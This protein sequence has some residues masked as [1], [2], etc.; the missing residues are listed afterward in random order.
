MYNIKSFRDFI[1]LALTVERKFAWERL[2]VWKTSKKFSN[3]AGS[4]YNFYVKGIACRKD[5]IVL[6]DLLLLNLVQLNR[7]YKCRNNICILYFQEKTL[8][9]LKDSVYLRIMN[10]YFWP[11]L[12]FLAYA[13]SARGILYTFDSET[14]LH[15]YFTM[16]QI[17]EK[18]SAIRIPAFESKFKRIASES[19]SSSKQQ[20]HLPLPTNIQ[21]KLVHIVSELG[22]EIKIWFYSRM[23]RILKYRN[24]FDVRNVL[25]WRSI[26]IID[27]FESARNLIRNEKSQMSPRLYVACKYYFEEDA[28]RLYRNM[29]SNDQQV[30]RRKWERSVSM[31]HWYRALVNNEALDWEQIS[32]NI[33]EDE[34]FLRN[35]NGVPYF[36]TRLRGREI[37]YMCIATCLEFK[38]LRSFDVYF[39]LHQFHADEL[40]N[41]ITR[42]TRNQMLQIFDSFLN[43]PLQSKFLDVVN[44]FKTRLDKEIFM[45]LIV[46]LLHKLECGWKDYEYANILKIFWDEFPSY[47]SSFEKKQDVLDRV[48]YVLNSPLP[49]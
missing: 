36:F 37:R 49:F 6:Y 30:I 8:S 44:R 43:W 35:Y 47:H 20:I 24:N 21:I 27:R 12:Q 7:K 31:R 41:V 46:G 2:P 13:R 48:N 5:L 34:F 28:Q 9:F 4:V 11:T 23:N 19:T 3:L 39:C 40:N 26:G 45:F 1:V 17:K 18:V 38:L 32:R 14:I 15:N 22:L 25:S 16:E 42:L 10:I 29:S 33:T